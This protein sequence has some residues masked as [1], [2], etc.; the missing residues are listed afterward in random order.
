MDSTEVLLDS[1]IHAHRPEG[2]EDDAEVITVEDHDVSRDELGTGIVG[3]S[4]LRV[5][6]EPEKITTPIIISQTKKAYLEYK[7]FFRKDL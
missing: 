6:N 4:D 7:N 5:S 1:S 3:P 2:E